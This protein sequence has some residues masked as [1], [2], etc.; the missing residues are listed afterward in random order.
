MQLIPV[1]EQHLPLIEKWHADKR[2]YNFLNNGEPIDIGVSLSSFPAEG[3]IY[4]RIIQHGEQP[5][6]LAM[7]YSKDDHVVN[8]TYFLTPDSQSQGLGK[9]MVQI[10]ID[11]LT[12]RNVKFI[13]GSTN[14]NNYPAWKILYDLGYKFCGYRPGYSRMLVGDNA[15]FA[16]DILQVWSSEPVSPE[17]ES[18]HNRLQVMVQGKAEEWKNRYAEI[19]EIS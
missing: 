3:P 4:A 11:F 16:G 9:Q 13:Y 18:L 14:E 7:F 2:I 12:A 19:T 10:V 5:V 1:T 17:L 8:P 15:E 6:G